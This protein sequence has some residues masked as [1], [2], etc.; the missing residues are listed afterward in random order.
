MAGSPGLADLDERSREVFGLIVD[1]WM[2]TGGP[3]GSRTLARKLDT[4]LSPATIRNVMADLQELGL[5]FSPHTSAGRLPTDGGLR[6]FVDGI[7]QTGGLTDSECADIEALCAGT[8]ITL[9]QSLE[10]ASRLLA[11]LTHHAGLVVAPKR[12]QRLNHIE[13]VNLGEARALAVMVDE[14]GQ[15]ENRMV[16]LPAGL[17]AD[18][19]QRASNYLQSRLSGRSLDEALVEIR[20]ELESR[21]AEIDTLAQSVVEAGLAVWAGERSHDGGRLIVTGRARLLDDVQAVED[22]ERLRG[23][24]DALETR[25]NIL[26]LVE[27]A[28]SGEGVQ[29][30]IGAENTVFSQTGMSMVVSPYR[31]GQER[32]VGAIGVLGPTR[33]NYAR[34]VPMVDYTARV[35]ERM[36]APERG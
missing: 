20:T 35:I 19:L 34:I 5:L 24:F 36:L 31:D 17:P 15:V 14:S 7:M 23:L 13:F 16:A 9:E 22:L 18:A 3:V 21:R 27:A 8:G 2:E 12:A 6:L 11:G 33:L 32:V 25:E 4:P 29:I 30:F 26:R 10:R 28:Q 1:A